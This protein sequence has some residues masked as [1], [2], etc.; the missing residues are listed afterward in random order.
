M[1]RTRAVGK[2]DGWLARDAAAVPAALVLGATKVVGTALLQT[3][4]VQRSDAAAAVK[5]ADRTLA[6]FRPPLVL[7]TTA[8]TLYNTHRVIHKWQ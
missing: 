4:P 6:R 3:R 8:V 2:A 1:P 7:Q 5:V